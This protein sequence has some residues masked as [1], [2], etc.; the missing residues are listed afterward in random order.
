MELLKRLEEYRLR[1][2]ITQEKLAKMLGVRLLTVNRW[3]KGYAKPSKINEYHIK[4][5]IEGNG[6]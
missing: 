3:L 2:R 4:K 5:L 1:N 6:K